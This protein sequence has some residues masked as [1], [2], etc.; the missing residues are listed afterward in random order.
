MDNSI[1]HGPPPA[2]PK[3]LE[4][5]NFGDYM[6]KFYVAWFEGKDIGELEDIILGCEYLQYEFLGELTCAFIATKIRGMGVED[7]RDTFGIENDF[8]D[9][10]ISQIREEN[11]WTSA[12]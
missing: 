1:K 12:L 7:M 2:M 6:H 5:N 11:K 10:E 9:D 3:P 4:S 8:G